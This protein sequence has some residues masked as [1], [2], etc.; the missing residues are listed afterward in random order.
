MLFQTAPRETKND[1]FDGSFPSTISSRRSIFDT[2][3]I[4]QGKQLVDTE[5]K[6]N[7]PTRFDRRFVAQVQTYG[8]HDSVLWSGKESTLTL[9]PIFKSLNNIT[10]YWTYGCWCFQMGDYP[11]RIGNGQPVDSVDR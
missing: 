2:P 9:L 10:K 5:H 8:E 1:D 11:L 4:K 7:Y 3:R 6:A